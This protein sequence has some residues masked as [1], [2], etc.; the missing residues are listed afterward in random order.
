MNNKIVMHVHGSEVNDGSKF[1]HKRIQLQ[2]LRKN[3]LTKKIN[4]SGNIGIEIIYIKVVMHGT[5]IKVH[6][7]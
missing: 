7:N 3:R 1:N 4:F 6:R 5:E 2:L